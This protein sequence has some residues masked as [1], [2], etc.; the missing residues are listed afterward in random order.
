VRSALLRAAPWLASAARATGLQLDLDS[1]IDAL[2]PRGIDRFDF[3]AEETLRASIPAANGLFTGRSLA[4]LYAALAG[5]GELDGVRLLSHETLQRAIR[6][7]PQ[8]RGRAV[9]PIDMRW[10][11]G[12]HAVFT[13]RGI[14]P[15]AFGHFGMGGSGGWADPSRELAFGLIVNGG[16][17]AAFNHLGIARIG[18]AALAAADARPVRRPLA[19]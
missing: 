6:E 16:I 2:A 13:T 7:Q 1:V 11:L 3:G 17:G 18:G 8:P 9:L 10:R 4:R 19:A 12:Y 15:A 5:G 14:P